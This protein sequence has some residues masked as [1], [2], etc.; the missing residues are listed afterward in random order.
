MTPEHWRAVERILAKLIA[1]W[2]LADHPDLL[3]RQHPDDSTGP[4]SATADGSLEV[5]RTVDG[6]A[7]TGS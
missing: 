3:Q 4:Q 7:I 6:P 2:Y 5:E 1:R